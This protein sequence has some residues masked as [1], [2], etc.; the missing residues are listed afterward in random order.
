MHGRSATMKAGAALLV[1][2][3]LA[4]GW[5]V[6]RRGTSRSLS[7]SPAVSEAALVP[8]PHSRFQVG[9]V[10]R[11]Q[12][13]PGEEASRAIVGRVEQTSSGVVI[14]HLQLVG[15]A[16]HNPHVPGGVSRLIQHVPMAEPQVAA[17]VVELETGSRQLEG[18]EQGYATWRDAWDR[19]T[20]GY[21]SISVKDAV[22]YM[23]DALS[24]G[25]PTTG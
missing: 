16:I 7:D 23:E 1:V 6:W 22:Q 19:K 10:W 24:K 18:F 11:Y 2:T 9:Q 3:L 15:L 12:T 14:V 8:A 20:G 5:V 21:F 4:V 25:R 13:R 17:S